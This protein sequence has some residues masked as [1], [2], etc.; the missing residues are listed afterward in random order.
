[1]FKNFGGFFNIK[2]KRQGLAL[3][4]SS[5]FVL[6]ISAPGFSYDTKNPTPHD[7]ERE[8]KKME[9]VGID[10]D[11][12]GENI[13]TNLI[14]FDEQG[15]PAPLKEFF[16]D[17]KP[18][19]LSMVY[20]KCPGLCNFHMN[21][22]VAALDKVRL[23]VNKDYRW[24]SVSMD[25]SETP[26]LAADKKQTYLDQEAKNDEA[27]QDQLKQGWK[28]LTGDEK[29]VETLTEQLGFT[30]RWDGETN[31]FAHAAA[32]YTITPDGKIAQIIPGIEFL[33][34]TIQLSLVDA[35]KGQIGTIVD[36]ISLFCFQFD[37]KKNKYTV[38]AYNFMKVGGVL[39]ILLL[40][41]F[42]VPNFYKSIKK[43][44]S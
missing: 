16:V 24:L 17:D 4:L 15:N 29:N 22:V 10:F 30:Y 34:Q 2:Q 31:Q 18:V 14:F 39:T 7:I 23:S 19:L 5:F 27:K 13:D 25:V 37:P 32:I 9:N 35:A 20:Y 28:F 33:P 36:R 38:Y 3:I 6:F 41:I 44:N 1:M 8:K 21:G 43:D 42:L 12:L 11:K 40:L 26:E